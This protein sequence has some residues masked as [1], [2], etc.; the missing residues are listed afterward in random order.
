MWFVKR[1]YHTLHGVWV[2]DVEFCSL[3]LG[4]QVLHR[5]NHTFSVIWCE[6]ILVPI[7]KILCWQQQ[8]NVQDFNVLS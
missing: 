2:R 8:K 7:N 4:C 5:M 6:T 3:G 1:I